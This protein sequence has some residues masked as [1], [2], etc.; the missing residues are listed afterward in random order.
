MADALAARG[1]YGNQLEAQ[2]RLTEAYADSYHLSEL[3]FRSGVDSFLNVLDSQ[4]QL[5]SAQQNLITLRQQQLSSLVT[6][7]KVLG[8]GWGA[9]TVVS[10]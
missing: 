9:G 4:R 6:L 8:G 3:R 2:Q 10:R 1:T 5:Y 7:Y